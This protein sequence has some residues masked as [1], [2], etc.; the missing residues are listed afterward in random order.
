M[1]LNLAHIKLES[2]KDK[3]HEV[4]TFIKVSQSKSH[5]NLLSPL[6]SFIH[7]KEEMCGTVGRFS[8]LL[9]LLLVSS[10]NL[11]KYFPQS[12]ASTVCSIA[13]L[14]NLLLVSTHCFLKSIKYSLHSAALVLIIDNAT[15]I[16]VISKVSLCSTSLFL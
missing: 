16:V 2:L 3:F 4:G 7:T 13:G 15:I 5:Y 9:P 6:A 14:P 12:E 1:I 11:L 8:F 10:L